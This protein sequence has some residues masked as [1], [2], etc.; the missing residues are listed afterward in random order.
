MKRH[1]LGL[2][3]RVQKAGAGRP[4]PRGVEED[5]NGREGGRYGREVASVD[6]RT[7][8]VVDL[9]CWYSPAPEHHTLSPVFRCGWNS[10]Q[11]RWIYDCPPV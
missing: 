1:E 9:S 6:V 3:L 8:L 10:E 2:L 5:G 11:S 7:F 4:N